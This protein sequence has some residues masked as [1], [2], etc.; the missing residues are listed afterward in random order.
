MEPALRFE[1]LGQVESRIAIISIEDHIGLRLNRSRRG[2]NR[3]NSAYSAKLS[4]PTKAIRSSLGAG[5]G[6]IVK[7]KTFIRCRKSVLRADVEGSGTGL[8]GSPLTTANQL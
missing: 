7:G 8:I 5:T 6:P 1:M 4:G 3:N 2:E